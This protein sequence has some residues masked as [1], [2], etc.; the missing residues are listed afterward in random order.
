M[1]TNSL[2]YQTDGTICVKL[3]HWVLPYCRL[4]SHSKNS[5]GDSILTLFCS[6]NE[7]FSIIATYWK[8]SVSF[9]LASVVLSLNRKGKW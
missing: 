5:I 2:S 4:E 6:V 3:W 7:S 8:R 1:K 9:D